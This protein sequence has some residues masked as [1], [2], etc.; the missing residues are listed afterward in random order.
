MADTPV[1]SIA[2]APAES[3]SIPAITAYVTDYTNA[4]DFPVSANPHESGLAPGANQDSFVVN[5]RR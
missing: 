1:G 5:T 3:A 2:T 4:G